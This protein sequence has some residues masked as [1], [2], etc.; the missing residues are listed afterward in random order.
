MDKNKN[1][2]ERVKDRTTRNFWVTNCP[3]EIWEEFNDYAKKETNN[4]Y[5]IAIKLLLGIAK[6]NAKESVMYERYI[7]IEKRIQD[8][9]NNIVEL[10]KGLKVLSETKEEHEIE[11]D[12]EEDAPKEPEEKKVIVPTMGSGKNIEVKDN[13]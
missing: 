9:E 2:Q 4:N 1:I 11:K 13:G 5:S 10:A 12:I 6:T 3:E 8:M 7:K